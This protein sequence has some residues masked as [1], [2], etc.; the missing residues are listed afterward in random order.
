MRIVER[1]AAG[2]ACL[3][4]EWQQLEAWDLQDQRWAIAFNI[5]PENVGEVVQERAKLLQAIYPLFDQFCQTHFKTSSVNL[6]GIL[7]RFWLPLAIQLVKRRQAQAQ[8]LIQGI[9]GGQGTGKTTLGVALTLILQHLGYQT[10]SLSLDDLY[11]TY[12]DRLRLQAQDPRLIW[13][14]P[15]G[16]H[17]IAL[18][19]EILDQLRSAAP[20]QPIAIPRFDKSR[21]QGSGDRADSE[22]VSN[23]EIVLFEGWFVGVRPVDPALFDQAP[24]PITTAADRAFARDINRQLQAYLPLWERLDSLMVL[25]PKDYRWS[26]EWRKQAEQE[27]RSRGKTGMDDRDIDA[28]V[29]YFW[30]ALHPDL[31]I[32]PLVERSGGADLVVEI[33]ANHAPGAIYRGGAGGNGKEGTPT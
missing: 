26:K 31:F 2:C 15:P 16:T 19:L 22:L 1:L 25:Y 24:P 7:W 6:P 28:F 4:E 13:R 33:D 8:P 3:P 30:K 20:G 17:D 21:H 5:G 32:N 10:L 12:G 14:G 9:L 18:G 27:M 23:V 11:K 29:D